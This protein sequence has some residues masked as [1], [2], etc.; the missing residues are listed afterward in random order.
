MCSLPWLNALRVARKHV[1]QQIQLT[2]KCFTSFPD[3]RHPESAAALMV[4]LS[5]GTILSANE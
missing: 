1:E 4:G 3:Q 5:K 2:G